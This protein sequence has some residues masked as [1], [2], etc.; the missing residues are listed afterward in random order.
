LYLNFYDSKSVLQTF[1]SYELI[2][3]MQLLGFFI[4]CCEARISVDKIQCG[5]FL[6][7]RQCEVTYNFSINL[8]DVKC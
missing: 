8:F 1:T 6:F 5:I 3:V 7:D 4:F 2:S